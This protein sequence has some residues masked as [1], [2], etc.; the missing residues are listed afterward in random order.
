[1]STDHLVEHVRRFG[2]MPFSSAIDFVCAD[3]GVDPHGERV[4][5]LPNGLV[6]D[7]GLSDHG[8]KAAAAIWDDK[9]LD[10][11]ELTT[12]FEVLVVY[13]FDGARMLDLPIARRPPKS[14]YRKPHWMPSVVR[15]TP[16]P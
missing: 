8:I 7:A 14:G 11:Q 10:M 9:R 1:M 13:G 2:D 12:P 15:L 3:A 5:D 6:F 16:P 4:A